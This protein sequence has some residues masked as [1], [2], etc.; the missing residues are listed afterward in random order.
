[1][2]L[3]STLPVLLLSMCFCYFA[4]STYLLSKLD[5]PDWGELKVPKYVKHDEILQ[6]TVVNKNI[7]KPAQVFVIFEFKDVK[8]KYCGQQH[9]LQHILTTHSSGELYYKLPLSAPGDAKLIRV[10]AGLY[11]VPENDTTSIYKTPKRAPALFSSW[12]PIVRNGGPP[13]AHVESITGILH[14]AYQQGLW[15]EHRG[16]DSLAGWVLTFGYLLCALLFLCLKNASFTDFKEKLF[17]VS[18]FGI[19]VLFGINKQLDLQLLITD[20]ARTVAKEY[21][22]YEQRKPFQIRVIA[23]FASLALG[24]FGLVSVLVWRSHKT[25]LLALAG[26]AV[27]FGYFVLRLVSYHAIEEIMKQ[28]YVFFSLYDVFELAGVALVGVGVLWYNRTHKYTTRS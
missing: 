3:N 9:H 15:R 12:L 27:I 23:L 10:S 1:M 8:G 6:I 28:R 18:L 21:Q 7:E 13:D 25:L 26:V 16:D 17:W 2:K 24:L 22:V 11:E 20:I 4:I 19:I 5:I 14:K